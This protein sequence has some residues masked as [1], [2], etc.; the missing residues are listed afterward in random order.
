MSHYQPTEVWLM[1]TCRKC[2]RGTRGKADLCYKCREKVIRARERAEKLEAEREAERLERVSELE[3][4]LETLEAGWEAER[5]K[6]EARQDA[7][8]EKWEQER[9]KQKAKWEA[10]PEEER[11]GLEAISDKELEELEARWDAERDEL[12][13]KWEPGQEELRAKLAELEP[14]Q[15]EEDPGA[16][17]GADGCLDLLSTDVSGCMKIGCLAILVIAIFWGYSSIKKSLYPSTYNGKIGII[18]GQKVNVR[19]ESSTS[20]K[21]MFQLNNGDTVTI[22]KKEWGWFQVKRDVRVGWVH[23]DFLRPT[24]TVPAP[25]RTGVVTGDNVNIRKEPAKDAQV[26]QALKRGNKVVIVE[27]R[28]DWVRVEAGGQTGWVSKKLITIQATK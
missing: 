15:E 6:L 22:L 12:V 19:S 13:A 5:E 8:R 7:E 20:S 1:G 4:A 9:E 25:K 16:D 10:M 23:D 28:G 2:G 24:D 14:E 18:S 17:S 3:T 26:L 27:E 21:A 11:T